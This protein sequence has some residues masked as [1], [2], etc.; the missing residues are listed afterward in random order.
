MNY[1]AHLYL[2]RKTPASLVGNLLGDFVKG[3]EGNLREQFP[4]AVVEGILMHR[5]ID[6]FTDKNKHFLE[7]KILL[8]SSMVRYAGIIIDI[9]FDHFLAKHW[10]K[11]E[12]S[13]LP[14]FVD[15]CHQVLTS[16]PE[17]H[18]EALKQRLPLII[19]DEVLLSYQNKEGVKTALERIS[20]RA[21]RPLSLVDAYDDFIRNYEEFEKIFIDFFPEL[22]RYAA[23]LAPSAEIINQ[24][25]TLSDDDLVIMWKQQAIVMAEKQFRTQSLIGHFKSKGVSEER[26]KAEAEKIVK[27]ITE[28][29]QSHQKLLK[30]PGYLLCV[31]SPTFLIIGIF[32][33]EHELLGNMFRNTI[34]TALLAGIGISMI[35]K[36]NSIR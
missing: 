13:P 7:A 34:T 15:H 17:W 24:E 14:E 19:R 16:H 4:D 27:E 3:N 5:K 21:K 22:C 36:A 26:A 35:K 11:Y 8:S 18:S 9:I 1:L 6:S 28:K 2:G 31:I 12:K 25:E 10:S 32:M 29:R 30:I 33:P 20:N 23:T